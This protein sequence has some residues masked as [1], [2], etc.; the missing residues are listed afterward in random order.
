MIEAYITRFLNLKEVVVTTKKLDDYSKESYPTSL[1]TYGIDFFLTREKAN[2]VL[3]IYLEK[4][5]KKQ[6]EQKQKREE[7]LSNTDILSKDIVQEV[8]NFICGSCGLPIGTFGHCG[9]SY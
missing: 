3:P 2:K 9:C 5:T 6:L 7:A 4:R 1:K 8:D